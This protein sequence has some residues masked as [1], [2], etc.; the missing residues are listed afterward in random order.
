M[1]LR[2]ALCL[3][4]LV[5]LSSIAKQHRSHTAITEFKRMHPCPATG[6]TKGRCPG[7]VIDHIVPLACDGQDAPHNMQWQTT[8]DAKAK[9]K[10]ERKGCT[11]GKR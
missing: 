10:W 3:F 2:L 1:I 9:D 11:P 8:A 5:P 6:K 4:L 7:Y